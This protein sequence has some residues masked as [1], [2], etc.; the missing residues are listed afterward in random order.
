M[1]TSGGVASQKSMSLFSISSNERAIPPCQ[2]RRRS[3][4][5]LRLAAVSSMHRL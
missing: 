3:S 1:R 2:E 4:A 5:R